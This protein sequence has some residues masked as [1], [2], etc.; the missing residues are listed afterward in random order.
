M[1]GAGRRKAL[2]QTR[3][4]G[5]V[6]RQQQAGDTAF[7]AFAGKLQIAAARTAQTADDKATLHARGHG[8]DQI[9][10]TAVGRIRMHHGKVRG[11]STAFKLAQLQI[12]QRT[13]TGKNLETLRLEIRQHH[14][15]GGH[16]EILA[17]CCTD[18]DPDRTDPMRYAGFLAC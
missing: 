17:P 15:H 18:A 4:D 11:A 1:F 8:A 5:D 2:G 10:H 6:I 12:I 14:H 7:D 3:S 13:H 16:V 9:D